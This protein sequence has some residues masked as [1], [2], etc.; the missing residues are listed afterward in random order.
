[1]SVQDERNLRESLTG[2]LE[3]ITPR[4]APVAGAVH[5]G[6]RIRTRRW[7]SAAVVIAVI[8]AGAAITPALLRSQSPPPTA[9]SGHR[10]PRFK[11]SMLPV[12]T[13]ARHGVIAAGISDGR[14]WQAVLS[15]SGKS[16][17]FAVKGSVASPYSSVTVGG[18]GAPDFSMMSV[19]DSGAFGIVEFGTVSPPITAMALRLPRGVVLTLKPVSYH[20]A[21]WVA[22]VIP[23]DV[24]ILRAV[25]YSG[26]RELDYSVPFQGRVLASWLRPGQAG[27]ARLS[28]ILGSGVVDGIKWQ[29]KAEIGP[30]GYCFVYPGGSTCAGPPGPAAP[31]SRNPVVPLG[32][33]DLGSYGNGP[34]CAAAAVA[35]DVRRVRLVYSDGSSAS[36]A[37][38]AVGRERAFAYA[39]PK[40][41]SVLRS[42]EYG[43][44]GQFVS[45]VG[46]SFWRLIS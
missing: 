5:Q 20:G 28:K 32:G 30:W 12:G 2:L 46:R 35:A 15:G 36:F 19:G 44:D 14:H 34:W 3:G 21:R 24:P 42:Y 23:A 31:T 45:M 9:P 26:G 1:V 18:P 17:A 8:A 40:G 4:P 16:E 41:M 25:T 22:V 29:L 10:V 11:V 13:P 6:M 37:T 33:A 39:I 27:P 7:I 38:V 43:P